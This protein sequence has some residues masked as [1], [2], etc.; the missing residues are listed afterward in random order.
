MN[1]KAKILIVGATGKIGS[2]IANALSFKGASLA[3]H[4]GNNKTAA[5]RL[6]KSAGANGAHAIVIHGDLSDIAGSEKI[7][8]EAAEK[9][10]GL[11]AMIFCAAYFKRSPIE[12][13]SEKT[14]RKTL[15]INLSAPFFCARHAA[16]IM[17]KNGGSILLFSDVAA[18]IPYAGFL[19]YSIAKAGLEAAVKGLAKNF[20]PKV[21]VNAIAPYASA[22]SDKESPAEWKKIISR[23]LVKK[24]SAPEELAELAK[25][26]VTESKTMTGEIITVDG[27]R[28]LK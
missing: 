12:K 28:L 5:E 10:G 1:K 19:P 11:D 17:K 8:D 2:A 20:A 15:D 6:A 23:T 22:R 21:R 9:L 14:W 27:G 4:Y 3:L 25:F 18:R 13:I 26:I 16:E 24:E 7:V